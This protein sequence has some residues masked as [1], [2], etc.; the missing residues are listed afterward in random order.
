VVAGAVEAARGRTR[1][2]RL[3]RPR[4]QAV[5]DASARSLEGFLAANVA[6]PAAVTTDGFKGYSGLTAAGHAHEPVTIRRSWGD[7]VLRMPAIHR[8]FGL[9]KRWPPGTHHGAVSA[10]HLQRYLDEYVFRFNR[11][12]AR[13]VAHR[14]ARLIQHAVQTPPATYRQIVGGAPA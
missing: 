6:S 8:V 2:R 13:S 4:L 3:G 5:P 7:A 12:T 1:G 10:K 14:F 11:R 9:A